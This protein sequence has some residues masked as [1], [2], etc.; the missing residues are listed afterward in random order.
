[1]ALNLQNITRCLI[2]VSDKT[3][4]VE[5]AEFLSQRNIEIISTG[6]TFKLLQQNHIK[7]T[8]ISEFT[9]FPEIMDGRVKTLHPKVHGGLLAIKDNA[10][11]NQQAQQNNIK[12]IDL[13]I[14]NLYPFIETVA[15]TNDSAEIIE[16]IDIGGPAMVRSASK[17][18]YYK[19]VITEIEQYQAL[20]NQLLENKNSTT[21]DFRIELAS[22][23]FNN[24]AKYDIAISDWF[25]N[26]SA[27]EASKM[28][29][30]KIANNENKDFAEKLNIELSL[31]QKLRYG[32]NSHQKGA[33]YQFVN[34]SNFSSALVG[35][36]QLQGK[37]LSYNNFNDADCAY[38]LMV[39]FSDNNEPNNYVCSIIKHSNP[40]GVAM[41]KS[42]IEAYQKALNADSKSAFGGIVAINANIDES[43][44]LLISQLFYEVIIANGF[45]PEALKILANKKNLRLLEL[46]FKSYSNLSFKSIAGGML[47]QDVDNHNFNLNQLKQVSDIALDSQ[48]L[49]QLLFAVKVCKHLKSNAIAVVTNFQTLG[50]GIG[51][52]NRV[53]SCE[54]ACKKAV[55]IMRT[56]IYKQY[57]QD[58]N[59]K[60]FLASD[61]FLPFAD[62]VEI[63]HKF[64]IKGVVATSGSIRDN[65]VI[66]K[67]NELGVALYFVETRH[68][69]H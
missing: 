37:E 25:A 50:L 35:A 22:K 33:V 5:L 24:I 64:G 58:K 11:H 16:N 63:A 26:F 52:T 10:L 15:K 54:I 17:N 27:V 13:L 30:E 69:R 67:A 36:K 8:E 48:D 21:L 3:G 31:K 12:N 43:L 65:E 66:A 9:E 20:K 61:A 57:Y 51:Q 14:V 18:F 39:E 28:N 53:D 59:A 45:T 41:A 62:N 6:G 60:L 46:D 4:I 55:D 34:Q 49:Q 1:M 42:P 29:G 47:V 56:D 68:F 2:S 7:V 44:A 32:E 38:N 19:T 23:A 40:C